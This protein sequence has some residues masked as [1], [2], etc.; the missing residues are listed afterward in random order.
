MVHEFLAKDVRHGQRKE[1]YGVLGNLAGHLKLSVDYSRWWVVKQG[2]EGTPDSEYSVIV[3]EFASFN[4]F[5]EAF[6]ELLTT[7]H[8]SLKSSEQQELKGSIDTRRCT[9]SLEYLWMQLIHVLFFPF[10]LK[11]EMHHLEWREYKD[12]MS[13]V[14]PT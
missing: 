5:T 11:V 2:K 7:E 3:V 12:K 9:G 6:Y 8:W 1:I 4:K 10:Y 13:S 14:K